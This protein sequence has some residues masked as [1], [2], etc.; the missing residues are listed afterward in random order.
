MISGVWRSHELETEQIP[1]RLRP[2]PNHLRVL[3]RLVIGGRPYTQ[4]AN[5]AD[6]HAHV[7][8]DAQ[9]SNARIDG[10][11]S[12]ADGTE[13]VDLGIERP[14]L[15][16]TPSA[17]VDRNVCTTCRKDRGESVGNGVQGTSE[18]IEAGDP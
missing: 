18:H 12:P 16:P 5:L 2:H 14:T 17:T 11:A 13:Q 10:E 9:P 1:V 15:R 4:R 8:C 6:G 3:D 7:D